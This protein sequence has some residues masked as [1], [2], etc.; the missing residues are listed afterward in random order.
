[1]NLRERLELKLNKKTDTKGLSQVSFAGSLPRKVGMLFKSVWILWAGIL[2]FCSLAEAS[3]TVAPQ[4]ME[5]NISTGEVFHGEY[6]VTNNASTSTVVAV[7]CRDWFRSPENQHIKTRD[8]LVLPSTPIS[9]EPG[10]EKVVPY[11]VIVPTSAQGAMVAMVSFLNR[12]NTQ[13]SVMISVPVYVV[14]KGTERFSWELSKTNFVQ[15]D[16]YFEAKTSVKNTGNIY[17]R[18]TG[19]VKI[20]DGKKL[21]TS[22]KFPETKPI[23][24]NLEKEISA[25]SGNFFL[26]K[27]KYRVIMLIENSDINYSKLEK[28]YK[29]KVSKAGEIEVYEEAN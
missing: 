24:P 6:R 7:S 29:L 27:G 13:L 28:H 17:F 1:M 26:K 18:P 9:L 2:I 8:W 25:R 14:V 16:Q 3:L 4:R 19:S 12:N 11:D 21:L 23:Y 5:I 20:Y 22:F 15:N 10:E